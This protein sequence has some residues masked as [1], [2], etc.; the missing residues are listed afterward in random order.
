[1]KL[2]ERHAWEERPPSRGDWLFVLA[3]AFAMLAV[4]AIPIVI[5]WFLLFWWMARGRL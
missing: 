5:L 3:I 2:L 4:I 1:M